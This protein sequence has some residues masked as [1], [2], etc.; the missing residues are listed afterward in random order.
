MSGGVSEILVENLRVLDSDCGVELKTVK[1]RGGY[2]RGI[3]VIDVF[4]ENVR[5]GIKATGESGSHPDDKFDPSE[6]PVVSEITFKDVVGVNVSLVGGVF[7][8]LEEMPFTSICLSNVSFF[9]VLPPD[10]SKSSWVC[11]NVVGSSLD[12]FPEPCPELEGSSSEC[13]VSSREISRVAIL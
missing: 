9:S 3:F 7:L 8:G 6:L 12:V 1:G 2:I 13:F 10:P 11:S 5:Q 4:L